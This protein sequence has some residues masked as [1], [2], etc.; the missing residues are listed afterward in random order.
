[1]SNRLNK[2]FSD[3]RQT[4]KKALVAYLTAGDP[5]LEVSFMAAIKAIE[6]GVDILEVGVP[7]SDPL[8]DGP[9]IQRAMGRALENGGGLHS[10]LDLIRKIRQVD[11]KTPVVLFGYLNPY[12]SIGEEQLCKAAV[13]AGVDGVLVVDLPMEEASGFSEIAKRYSL[14]WIRLIA[15]TSGRERSQRIAE[16]ASGFIYLVA[17]TGVT[18][19]ALS[20]LKPVERMISDVGVDSS[21]PMCVG[22]GI[23]SGEMAGEVA[24][25]ADGVVVGSAL[26]QILE[27]DAPEADRL[28]ELG[29]F[30]AELRRGIDGSATE[31]RL[32]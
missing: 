3:L 22:F 17:M 1:M 26:V 14:A 18:G 4:G 32:K 19:G 2:C 24:K 28:A 7:F 15:P 13:E 29:R 23:R 11:E 6:N 10:A 9:V 16:D 31:G 30:V 5:N 27:L 8:A 21:L 25:I 12:I 20:S